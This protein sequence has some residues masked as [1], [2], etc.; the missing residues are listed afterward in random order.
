MGQHIFTHPSWKE[1]VW[2]IVNVFISLDAKR[3]IYVLLLLIRDG[4][5]N[6]HGL[7]LIMLK[8]EYVL[9]DSQRW[10]HPDL[11]WCFS[12]FLQS[13]S[14]NF[15]GSLLPINLW[16]SGPGCFFMTCR[17]CLHKVYAFLKNNN[18][19]KNK[20]AESSAECSCTKLSWREHGTKKVTML[21]SI[22]AHPT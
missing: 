20:S 2:F 19:C 14:L 5:Q 8:A 9:M 13:A 3:F 15:I 22:H 16:R 1:S 12:M 21:D 11:T 7:T 4:S 6:E 10:L 17:V 18:G